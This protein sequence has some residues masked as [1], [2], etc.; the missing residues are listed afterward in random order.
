MMKQAIANYSPRNLAEKAKVLGVRFMHNVKI[1]R[2]L[3]ENSQVGW[4]RNQCR[5]R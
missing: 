2:L 3:T 4:C 1:N 5:W